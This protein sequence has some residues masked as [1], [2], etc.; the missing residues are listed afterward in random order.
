MINVTRLA[1]LAT[2]ILS[3]YLHLF[4]YRYPECMD[5]DITLFW[6]YDI[7]PGTASI[8]I[9]NNTLPNTHYTLRPLLLPPTPTPPEHKHTLPAHPLKHPPPPRPPRHNRQLPIPP[10]QPPLKN[11]KIRPLQPP[12][13]SPRRHRPQQHPPIP[14]PRANLPLLPRLRQ[15]HPRRQQ[16]VVRPRRN[17]EYHVL[18]PLRCPAV[19][20]HVFP[21]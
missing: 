15:H 3:I 19:P 4:V 21:A 11:I 14:P 6:V 8:S 2:Y 9:P 13:P 5:M 17:L 16:V 18:E 7:R 10:P 20:E 12:Q 1:W